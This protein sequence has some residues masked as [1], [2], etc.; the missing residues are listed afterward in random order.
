MRSHA[1]LSG[2]AFLALLGL[3]CVEVAVSSRVWHRGSPARD[4]PGLLSSRSD[5]IVQQPTWD[6]PSA[7]PVQA[8]ATSSVRSAPPV[9]LFSGWTLH[10][11]FGTVIFVC[12]AAYI[13]GLAWLLY[14]ELKF[15]RMKIAGGEDTFSSYLQYR[16]AE[17]F[18]TDESAPSLVLLSLT[19]GLIVVGAI[20]YVLVVGGSLSHSLWRIFVWST[21]SPAE[22]EVTPGG[23]FLGTLVTVAGLIILSL[24]LGIVTDVFTTKTSEIK[25]GLNKVVE[26]GHVLILGYTN[27]TRCLLMELAISRESENGGK[28]VILAEQGK[29]EIDDFLSSID[30]KSS[31]AVARSGKPWAVRDLARVAA[32]TA[33]QIV[34][35]SD[36]SGT[37]EEADARSVQMLLALKTRGWPANGRIIVQCASTANKPLVK[38]LYPDKVEVVVVGDIVAKLM[39]QASQQSCLANVFSMMLG[40][41]GNEFYAQEWPDL[42]GISFR[43]AVFRFPEACVIGLFT[44]AGECMI[45]PGWDYTLQQGDELIVLAL[46]ND[47]YSPSEQPYYPIWEQPRTQS[48]LPHLRCKTSREPM[49]TT[50]LLVG[51]NDNVGPLLMALEAMVA[52]TSS[53][54]IYSSTPIEERASKI[55]AAEQQGLAFEALHISHIHVE[56]TMMTSRLELEKLKLDEFDRILI[57]AEGLDKDTADQKSLAI[58]VQLKYLHDALPKERQKQFDPVV[59]MCVDSTADHLHLCGFNNFVHSSSLVSQALAA[60]TEEPQVNDIYVELM[61]GE[62]NQFEIRR[63][64]DFLPPHEEE[65]EQLSFGEAAYRICLAG[66]V[67]LVAWSI[68]SEHGQQWVL[69]PPDKCTPRPWTT[70]DRLAVIRRF[71]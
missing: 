32:N 48:P 45:N 35:L 18:T 66:D 23:R 65:P 25:A 38:S 59:E 56:E 12:S 70:E 22:G 11:T 6:T 67:S 26:G 8:K 47:A 51:W 64:R 53:L 14:A 71:E 49:P 57:L 43:E 69:N 10:H 36:T 19:M 27:C 34:I 41:E 33:S 40:F 2:H 21:G 55:A 63:F 68:Q 42:T 50:T 62:R 24:L 15:Y 3:A 9:G 39:A 31:R 29:D 52:S 61:S 16:F 58:M 44:A 7:A 1:L 54:H 17:W 20:L 5:Q 60:V 37:P 4:G 46:D 13:C 30:L 28:F